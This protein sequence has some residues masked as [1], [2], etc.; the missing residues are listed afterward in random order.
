MNVRLAVTCTHRMCVCV[1][2]L[3]CFSNETNK[4]IFPE[5]YKM[6]LLDVFSLGSPINGLFVLIISS[7]NET[8][9]F[10]LRLVLEHFLFIWAFLCVQIELYSI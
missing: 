3:L 7:I 6:A 1:C 5:R 2:A 4:Y 9:A 8:H 10:E